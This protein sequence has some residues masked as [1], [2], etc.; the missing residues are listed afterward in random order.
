MIVHTHYCL[1]VG[2]YPCN[3]I[4][5]SLMTCA[6]IDPSSNKGDFV[7]MPSLKQRN[8]GDRKE[9]QLHRLIYSEH[10]SLRHDRTQRVCECVL[11]TIVLGHQAG[12]REGLRRRAPAVL[13]TRATCVAK[14]PALLLELLQPVMHD[15][16]VGSLEE[17]TGTHTQYIYIYISPV[18][19]H[20]SS[21]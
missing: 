4:I 18:F 11:I 21:Y 8:F 9:L 6:N 2:P 10:D 16:S 12:V 15:L 1:A 3:L 13:L 19:P 5:S 17:H 7:R 14:L 20:T